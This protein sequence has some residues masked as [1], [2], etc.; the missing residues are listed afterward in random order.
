MNQVHRKW[1]AS[2][3]PYALPLVQALSFTLCPH[4]KT[5]QSQSYFTTGGLP[6]ISSSWRQAPCGSWPEIFL[7][8]PLRPNVRIA[9]LAWEWKKKVPFYNIYNSSV[10]PGFTR[11]IMLNSFNSNSGG[12]SPTGST[13]HVGHQLAYCTCPG[14]LWGWRIWWN[15]DWQGK[16]KYS[17]KTCPSATLSSTSPT[18]PDRARTRA[19]AVESQWLAAWAMA[20]SRSCL[21]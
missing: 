17:E 12:C 15:D 11:Q 20:R 3:R 6:S 13:W 2:I 10:S 14:W 21:P 5:S 18:W 8:E 7:T 16:P 9:Y 4:T 19:A 1:K